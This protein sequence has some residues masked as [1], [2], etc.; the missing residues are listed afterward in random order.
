M[1]YNLNKHSKPIYTFSNAS[2]NS[3]KYNQSKIRQSW[4]IHRPKEFS[5]KGPL[6]HEVQAWRTN[7]YLRT[8]AH[9]HG[10]SW[11]RHTTYVDDLT[12]SSWGVARW[13]H[14]SDSLTSDRQSRS[15]NTT[16]I[17]SRSPD[18]HRSCITRRSDVIRRLYVIGRS[19]W[20]HTSHLGHTWVTRRSDFTRYVGTLAETYERRG[21]DPATCHPERHVPANRRSRDRRMSRKKKALRSYVSQWTRSTYLESSRRLDKASLPTE[22]PGVIEA[23]ASWLPL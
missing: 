15:C 17:G 4:V 6:V 18:T 11:P 1:K 8:H 13:R 10:L 16:D 2:T 22:V 3:T 20:G 12:V 7:V 14:G 21:F 5:V 23:V 19:Y 9:L